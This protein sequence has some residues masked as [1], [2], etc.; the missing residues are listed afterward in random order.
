MSCRWLLMGGAVLM[1]FSSLICVARQEDPPG[2]APDAG[3]TAAAAARQ[4]PILRD[5][6]RR[7]YPGLDGSFPPS[8]EFLESFVD[9]QIDAFASDVDRRL[10]Q[11][12]D[13]AAIVERL[14]DRRGAAQGD[15]RRQAERS[16]KAVL[17]LLADDCDGLADRLQL[18]FAGL[19]RRGR[20]REP[21][22]AEQERNPYAMLFAHIQAADRA[23]R[24]YLFTSRQVVRVEDLEGEDM[25]MR[26]DA[27]E[28]L[29]RELSR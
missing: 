25:L 21:R 19:N 3:D 4:N 26:L 12:T 10:T 15:E 24:D 2:A 28:K 29:A 16:L 22:A 11:I 27:A 8:D 13:R 1:G 9:R 7:L 23:I 18:V 17:R 14:L 20:N 5:F 6:Y